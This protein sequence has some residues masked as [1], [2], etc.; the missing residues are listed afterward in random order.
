MK[1]K[2]ES[3]QSRSLQKNTLVTIKG[4][5]LGLSDSTLDAETLNMT[6]KGGVVK[7]DSVSEDC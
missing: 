6:N 2:L 7:T 4:G 5:K 1:K 3:L